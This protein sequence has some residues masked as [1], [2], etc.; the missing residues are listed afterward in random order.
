MNHSLCHHHNNL[1]GQ[2]L[3]CETL[4][5]HCKNIYTL[6]T[7]RAPSLRSVPLDLV[8]DL[9]AFCCNLSQ[10]RRITTPGS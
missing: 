1:I 4:F 7:V 10:W 9:K 2:Y 5:V 3:Q 6:I 8:T